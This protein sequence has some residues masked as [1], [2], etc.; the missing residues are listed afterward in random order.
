MATVIVA[1]KTWG[2][3]T[4]FDT[5]RSKQGWH[6]SEVGMGGTY[7]KIQAPCGGEARISKGE[8]AHLGGV[9]VSFSGLSSIP[10]GSTHGVVYPLVN[11]PASSCNIY[12]EVPDPPVVPP[13]TPPDPP[14]PPMN[15]VVKT[16]PCFDY[17][18]ADNKQWDGKYIFNGEDFFGPPKT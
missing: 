10:S 5:G 18:R 2:N 11:I 8:S 12:G 7:I 16:G 3:I 14:A 4:K 15:L 1:T 13:P 6:Y 9:L 17:F